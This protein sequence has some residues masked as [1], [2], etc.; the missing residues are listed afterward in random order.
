M[1]ERASLPWGG[2]IY[3]HCFWVPAIMFAG[4]V[5]VLHVPERPCVHSLSAPH[6]FPILYKLPH[7]QGQLTFLLNKL[8]LSVF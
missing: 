1:A 7:L 2:Y 4:V 3:N 8:M 6:I 5:L